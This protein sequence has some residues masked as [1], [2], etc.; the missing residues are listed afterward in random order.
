MLLI[1]FIP[2]RSHFTGTVAQERSVR[3]SS[4]SGCGSRAA[5]AGEVRG[6]TPESVAEADWSRGLEL[7]GEPFQWFTGDRGVGELQELTACGGD[8]PG[9][10]KTWPK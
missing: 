7:P 4:R 9:E 2:C 3:A 1:L 10:G 8:A 5:P 6:K